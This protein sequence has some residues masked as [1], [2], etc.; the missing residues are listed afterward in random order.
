[1]VKT[2]KRDKVIKLVNTVTDL[3][4]PKAWIFWAVV[5]VI[6]GIIDALYFG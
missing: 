5:F 2:M 3:H 4:N 1:M 6:S